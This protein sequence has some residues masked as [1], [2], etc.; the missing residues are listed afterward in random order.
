MRHNSFFS[1]I[2]NIILCVVI[3]RLSSVNQRFTFNYDVD[4]ALLL[5]PFWSFMISLIALL[6]FNREL[7]AV[8]SLSSLKSMPNTR[9]VHYDEQVHHEV[10]V[11]NLKSIENSPLLTS[12]IYKAP[13]TFRRQQCSIS[14]PA[15]YYGKHVFLI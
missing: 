3:L 11:M 5:T 4:P 15:G 9:L 1:N 8:G 12:L 14:G 13:K 7:P 2:T 10:Y 6:L